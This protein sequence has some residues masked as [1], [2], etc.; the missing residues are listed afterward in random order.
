M[1]PAYSANPSVVN[2]L[3][4][5]RTALVKNP[6]DTHPREIVNFISASGEGMGVTMSSSVVATMP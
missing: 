5:E 4:F 3:P 2:D 1:P 6:A